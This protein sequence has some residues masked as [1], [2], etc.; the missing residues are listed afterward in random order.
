MKQQNIKNSG[1]SSHYQQNPKQRE[2]KTPPNEH[3]YTKTSGKGSKDTQEKTRSN[4]T[5]H[6]C[7]YFHSK[8]K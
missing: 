1:G 6:I 2:T 7:K 3:K 5:T 4:Q 8:E